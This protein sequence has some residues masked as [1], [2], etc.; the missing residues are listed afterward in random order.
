[1]RVRGVVVRVRPSGVPVVRVGVPDHVSRRLQLTRLLLLLAPP[2]TTVRRRA[3]VARAGDEVDFALAG[4][5]KVVA[6]VDVL[7]RVERG[8]HR[9]RGGALAEAAVH[10]EDVGVAG[11]V[12]GAPEDL[13]VTYLVLGTPEGLRAFESVELLD[14]DT[15]QR[16]EGGGVGREH[17]RWVRH[18]RYPPIVVEARG[19]GVEKRRR[20]S[21]RFALRDDIRKLQNK[22]RQ[23]GLVRTSSSLLARLLAFFFAR[24]L[25]S[26][27]IS[28]STLRAE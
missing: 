2:C 19:I 1:M 20:T 13:L 21:V 16:G 24:T 7:R 4:E 9:C 25:A 18:L 11:L 12:L 27:A 8:H 14:G 26:G 28:T 23:R 22:K 3:V 17:E 5:A 6:V 10:G 15:R